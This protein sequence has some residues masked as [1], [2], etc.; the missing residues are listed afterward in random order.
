MSKAEF[1]LDEINL[2]EYD[3]DFEDENFNE[4]RG[5]YSRM[6]GILSFK[7]ILGSLIL[8]YLNHADKAKSHNQM[9]S[10]ISYEPDDI[11]FPNANQEND[12]IQGAMLNSTNTS[13]TADD[14]IV[15]Q[16]SVTTSSVYEKQPSGTT[17][18]T[19]QESPVQTA[20]EKYHNSLSEQIASHFSLFF[21]DNNDSD[22]THHDNTTMFSASSLF[23]VGNE[24]QAST[25]SLL[26]G[27]SKK[28]IGWYIV[29]LVFLLIVIGLAWF[30]NMSEVRWEE[31]MEAKRSQ[32]DRLSKE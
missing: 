13:S 31:L 4:I 6:K 12:N 23:A 15:N 10:D 30:C 17:H 29:L 5:Y 25:S 3:E 11:R 2:F 32:M 26:G 9:M 18:T 7:I 8:I 27:M 19:P 24:K 20:T 22:I 14:T 28:R 1:S 16:T 21:G